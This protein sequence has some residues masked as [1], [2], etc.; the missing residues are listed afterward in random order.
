[1]F[2]DV[3]GGSLLS[4]T[5]VSEITERLWAEYEAFASRD[6]SE[7]AVTYL[8]VDGLAEQ[9]HL[10]QPHEAVL[11]AWGILSDGKKALL[12]LAPGDQGGYRE[13]PR[14]L[15][16]PAPARSARRAAGGQRRSARHDPRHRGMS[17][18]LASPALLGAQDEKSAKQDARRRLA[19]VQGAPA[20]CYQAASPALARLLRDDIAATYGKD[21]PSAVA[22]HDDDFEACIAICASRSAIAG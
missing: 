4:R 3:N 22:C 15:P 21:L 10:G 12:H 11:A 13:L 6:L 18:A 9:L 7:F 5:A 8:F 2:A 1:V 14:V 17:A 16:R 20:A 19:G